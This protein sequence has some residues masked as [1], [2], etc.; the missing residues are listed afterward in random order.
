[1]RQS[2]WRLSRSVGFDHRLS[3]FRIHEAPLPKVTSAV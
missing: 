1:M 3:A 2:H